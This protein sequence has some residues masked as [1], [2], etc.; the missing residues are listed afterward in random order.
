M[1]LPIKGDYLERGFAEVAYYRGSTEQVSVKMSK[2]SQE[3]TFGDVL[4]QN[5]FFV[6][7]L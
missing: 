3:N 6:E 5:P 1:E 7:H 2:N 4:F